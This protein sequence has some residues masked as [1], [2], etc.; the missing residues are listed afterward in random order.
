MRRAGIWLSFL[1]H[2]QSGCVM[3]V[4]RAQDHLTDCYLHPYRRGQRKRRSDL[5]CLDRISNKGTLTLDTYT[6]YF[7]VALVELEFHHG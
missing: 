7:S 6:V 1:A 3:I 2:I 5:V 4:D